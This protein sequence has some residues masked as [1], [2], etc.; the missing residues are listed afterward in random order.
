MI[1][2]IP[3][4]NWLFG[5]LLKFLWQNSRGGKFQ[6]EHLMAYGGMPSTHSIMVASL[7]TIVGITQGPASPLFSVTFVSALFV[8]S[9][10]L[11]LRNALAS[12]SKIVNALRQNL[13]ADQKLSVP[14]AP[15]QLGHTFTEIAAGLAIGVVLTLVLYRVMKD[16]PLNQFLLF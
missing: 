16:W 14:K 5:Q 10:A 7:A 11:K 12:Q 6:L 1:I 9:D 13:A 2:L 15:E 3:L 8:I 4:I